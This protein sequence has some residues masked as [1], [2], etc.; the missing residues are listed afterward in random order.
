M[1][2]G[3]LLRWLLLLSP[4]TNGML[5]NALHASGRHPLI[6][7]SL[8]YRMR[9]I[10]M[11]CD[12][13]FTFQ[14][15]GHTMTVIEVEG[16]NIEPYVVDSIELYAGTSGLALLFHNIAHDSDSGQRYSFVVRLG[17]HLFRELLLMSPLAQREPGRRQLL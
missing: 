16:N 12:P 14:I 3:L 11:A 6:L 15:D 9:M 7:D 17:S 2:T 1:L 4:R 13:H 5:G 8:S 10:S